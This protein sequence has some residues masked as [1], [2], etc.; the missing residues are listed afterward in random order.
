MKAS[1]RFM[2]LFGLFIVVSTFMLSSAAIAAQISNSPVPA[3]RAIS[4]F[5]ATTITEISVN[6]RTTDAVIAYMSP[7]S[8]RL[9][10]KFS[11]QGT[12]KKS[13]SVSFYINNNKVFN[14]EGAPSDYAVVQDVDIPAIGNYIFKCVVDENNAI[15][16][17][18][19]F[20]IAQFRYETCRPTVK[21]RLVPDGAYLKNDLNTP[22]GRV[23]KVDFPN[24]SYPPDQTFGLTG[25]AIVSQGNE[26][27]CSYGSAVTYKSE[28]MNAKKVINQH[29]YE[30]SGP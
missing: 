3:D 15:S 25:S 24:F 14:K 7:G 18:M 21:V 5:S 27:T 8:I 2:I 22:A 10:C 28:C 4:Q 26:V 17:E 16:K 20:Q 29:K 13:H 11:D 19:P 23:N 12:V 30:C 6:F 1:K 9:I